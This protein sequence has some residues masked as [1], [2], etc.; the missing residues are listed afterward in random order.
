MLSSVLETSVGLDSATA[1]ARYDDAVLG[2]TPFH[3]LLAYHL[4]GDQVVQYEAFVRRYYKAA[5]QQPS[6]LGDPAAPAI[7]SVM[8]RQ[9][10][11]IAFT[12]AME[13]L[14]E[15]AIQ[16]SKSSWMFMRFRVRA[17]LRRQDQAPTNEFDGESSVFLDQMVQKI[18]EV[19]KANLAQSAASGSDTDRRPTA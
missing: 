10:L 6:I 3:P 4:R 7:L 9:T 12:K 13:Q 11:D 18:E 15:D 19:L 2:L 5:R 16:V 14:A 8:E 17:V 1:S